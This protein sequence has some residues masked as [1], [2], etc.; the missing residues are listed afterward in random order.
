METD[1]SAARPETCLYSSSWTNT[2]P[3]WTPSSQESPP[4]PLYLHSA[5][6]GSLSLCVELRRQENVALQQ[7]C[8]QMSLGAGDPCPDNARHVLGGDSTAGRLSVTAHLTGPLP[9]L[10]FTMTAFYDKL[11]RCYTGAVVHG[12][13]ATSLPM[14][15][16]GK[17]AFC[18]RR[19]L[20]CFRKRY[21]YGENH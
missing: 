9:F 19:R 7:S 2:S 6:V 16:L 15:R 13:A 4:S 12:V 14:L 3:R 17:A 21:G 8:A 10:P 18:V 20:F 11:A 1:T 5:H